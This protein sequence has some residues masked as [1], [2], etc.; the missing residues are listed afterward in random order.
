MLH[1]GSAVG[2][3]P[4]DALSQVAKGLNLAL[5]ESN[6]SVRVALET[7][8]GRGSEVGVNFD[9]LKYIIDRVNLKERVGIC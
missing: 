4:E 2:A 1:P 8:C 5:D 6:S 9:Q 7:M 3:K